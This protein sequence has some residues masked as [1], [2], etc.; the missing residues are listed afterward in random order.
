[1]L[2]L[3]THPDR[4]AERVDARVRRG[5]AAVRVVDEIR[6]AEHREIRRD[7]LP[8]AELGEPV[9]REVLTLAFRL[10]GRIRPAHAAADG[11]KQRGLLV[12]KPILDRRRAVDPD[13]VVFWSFD[14]R[15]HQQRSPAADDEARAA[16]VL[17]PGQYHRAA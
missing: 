7:F 14:D 16:F 6:P 13:V 12:G 3:P 4:E 2:E 9:Q 17:P 8:D 15:F 11:E 10:A 5:L 1:M